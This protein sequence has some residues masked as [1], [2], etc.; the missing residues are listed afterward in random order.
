MSEA[1]VKSHIWVYRSSLPSVKLLFF[2]LTWRLPLCG[3]QHC[4]ESFG[5]RG[6][7]AQISFAVTHSVTLGMSH[8]FS[9]SSSSSAKWG[10]LLMERGDVSMRKFPKHSA[11][12]QLLVEGA[13]RSSSRR[14]AA[15]EL[16]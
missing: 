11:H 14:K 7:W 12:N 3:K 2:S 5:I 6:I 9:K 13:V 8:T 16:C 15:Q 1:V 4:A 10:L